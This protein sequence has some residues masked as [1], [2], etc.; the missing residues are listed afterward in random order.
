[1]KW[2]K[3]SE[4]KIDFK[5]K[6]YAKWVGNSFPIKSTG[7]FQE[8]N[9]TFFWNE[10][11]YVPVSKDEFDDLFILD[12]TESPLP[13]T[14]VLEQALK[15]ISNAPDAECFDQM[16]ALAIAALTQYKES[17]TVKP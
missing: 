10:R 7:K 1:M 2:T 17:K 4:I 15:D 9:G 12:E 5:E 11:G 16:K 13:D 3:A 6:Y 8:S 14:G